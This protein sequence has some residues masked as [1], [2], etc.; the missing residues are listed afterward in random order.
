MTKRKT[1]PRVEPFGRP[2]KYKP[3]YCQMLIDHMKT[4]LSYETFSAII[5]VMP[6]TIYNWEKSQPDFLEAKKMAF[7]ESRVF[8]E[9]QGVIGL[10]SDKDGPKLNTGV[11]AFNM[12]NRFGW[13]DRQ[14][15]K[16]ET[17]VAVK[18]YVIKRVDGSEVELGQK[19][20]EKKD[21]VVDAEEV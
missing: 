5:N 6:A 9:K 3:E 13:T 15:V 4:G 18:P 14:E 19:I 21:D 11:W 17:T 7:V 12:K 8:W 10:F 16:Q 1:T 2:T 20:E